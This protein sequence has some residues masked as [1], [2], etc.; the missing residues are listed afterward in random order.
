MDMFSAR[1]KKGFNTFRHTLPSKVHVLP[2]IEVS[3]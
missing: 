1:K 2:R 3:V